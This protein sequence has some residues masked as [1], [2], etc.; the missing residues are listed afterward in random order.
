MP[1]LLALTG[2]AWL[3]YVTR[4]LDLTPIKNSEGYLMRSDHSL[5]SKQFYFGP[6]PFVTSLM[7]KFYGSTEKSAVLGQLVT[8]TVSWLVLTLA[9]GRLIKNPWLRLVHC[10]AF[11]SLMAWWNVMG[12][13]M[14]MRAESTA[15][16]WLALWCAALV[17]YCQKP[18]LWQAGL[19]GAASFFL[20]FTRD[21]LPLLVLP[22]VG[23]VL[24]VEALRARAGRARFAAP[25]RS[26]LALLV[27]ALV[28]IA[29]FQLSTSQSVIHPQ[30]K[31]RHEFPLV[32]V[33]IQRV[34][35]KPEVR[36]WFE[37]RGM[38]VH[39]EIL[40]WRKKWASGNRFAIFEKKRYRAF[41]DWVRSE[42]KYTYLRYLASHPGYT[43][44]SA[45]AA[46]DR[47]FAHSLDYYTNKAPKRFPFRALDFALP[48][49]SP[50]LA[51]L[52][53]L[54]GLWRCLKPRVDLLTIAFTAVIP[55]T[56]VNGLFVFHMD[57]MEVERHA[58]LGLVILQ[59][60]SYVLVL[61]W[62]RTLGDFR[63]VFHRDAAL[64]E[65]RDDQLA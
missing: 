16:S 8:S 48:L 19:L 45:F 1:T 47:I 3:F 32:N 2:V 55:L 28:V 63:R 27:G 65:R 38:P 24:T 6:R 40:K 22:V 33:V 53:G 15:F 9:L 56:L 50:A 36:A 23:V 11:P 54:W 35:P 60:A 14:V 17:T 13:N 46:R 64:P 43:L 30:F 51:C 20:C 58:I 61:A 26:R 62:G 5:W 12:W 57:A 21:S 42:G 34:L 10:L 7:Y 44:K 4:V 39:L 49:V 31:T 18:A 29:G 59:I 52:A 25:L 41:R 37:E